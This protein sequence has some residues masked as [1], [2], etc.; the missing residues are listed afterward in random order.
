MKKVAFH[1]LGCK[2][3]QVE[4]EQMKEDF[5]GHGYK[6][7]DFSDNADIYVINTCTVT[8]VSDRKSRAMIRR[9]VRRNPQALVVAVGCLI[10]V[11][12]Q[13]V[14][15]IDGVNLLVGNRD[16]H[17]VRTLIEDYYQDMATELRICADP[18][19]RQD[20]LEA[21][22]YSRQHKRT[23]AFV[24]IQDGCE[25]YCSYC[26]V[27]FAR[28]PIRSKLAENV[29]QEIRQ[30]LTLGYKEIVLTG[31]H[32]GFYGKD[33][34]EWNL[35]RLLRTILDEVKGEYRI[36]LSS[37]E[38][39]E[40]TDELLELIAAEEKIC[41][42]FHIPLQ[43][44]SDR[45][46]KS[47]GRRYDRSYYR[48]LIKRISQKIPDAAFTAD[49]MVGYP[50]EDEKDFQDSYDL[51]NELPVYDLHVFKYSRRPGTKAYSFFPQI[52][53]KEKQ[54]RSE[55]LL[56]L[57]RKKRE[58]FINNFKFRNLC[59]LVERKFDNNMYIGL[60]DNYIEIVFPSKK[61][62]RGSFVEVKLLDSN[63]DDYFL[64]TGVL[65]IDSDKSLY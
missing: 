41:H 49:I 32:T 60:S 38:P 42:H 31:I 62:L 22:L 28:G 19:S 35:H 51:I 7:V 40:M 1:T 50:G 18:I 34:E 11:D 21:V 24:K 61:D 46:L 3:N 44:G 2:V 59:L 63:D 4:T 27:P 36:R 6:I 16:K 9:A 17:K 23:R 15:K 20:K 43:S 54:R 58:I 33:L 64:A 29:I 10:Q 53:E 5:I 13:Q 47:M 52:E 39:L 14:E 37:I 45:I 26:I 30:L 12:H 55:I 48:D 65:C 57:A 25:S 56:E 8:H